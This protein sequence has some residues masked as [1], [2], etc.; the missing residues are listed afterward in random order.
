ME[1]QNFYFFEN[2]LSKK[3]I[4]NDV[5]M[6]KKRYFLQVIKNQPTST[7]QVI[8]TLKLHVVLLLLFTLI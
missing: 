8:H 3:W 7:D 1:N 2:G 5:P 4:K 6:K